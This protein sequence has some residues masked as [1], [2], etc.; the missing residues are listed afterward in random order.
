MFGYEEV[1]VVYEE[2]T[3]CSWWRKYWYPNHHFMGETFI[4]I[5]HAPDSR[6]RDAA[7]L[8]LDDASVRTDGRFLDLAPTAF[9]RRVGDVLSAAFG[10]EAIHTGRSGDG[11]ID[12]LLF[13]SDNGAIAVQVKHRRSDGRAEGVAV[14]RELRGAMVLAGVDRGMIVT[15]ASHFS[16][17]ARSAAQ[18]SPDHLV[19]QRIEL[20]DARRLLAALDLIRVAGA[21]QPSDRWWADPLW[22]AVNPGVD[23]RPIRTINDV[24]RENLRGLD[25]LRRSGESR[26]A[27]T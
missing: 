8:A 21:S 6:L 9:E 14:V 17:G 19:P 22:P 1:S 2:C 23:P 16:I 20:I 18:P 12:L 4:G 7:T 10:C 25:L 27:D 26:E 15:T 5:L 13:D 24:H 11:G 3:A